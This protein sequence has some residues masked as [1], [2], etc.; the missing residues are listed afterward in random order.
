MVKKIYRNILMALALLAVENQTIESC[1][2]F[3][4]A[5]T[6]RISVFKAELPGMHAFRP[7][8]YTPEL[9]YA[10][11]APERNSDWQAN[12]REWNKCLG[13]NMVPNDIYTILYQAGPEM[14]MLAVS[15]SNLHQT[16]EGNTF[17]ETLLKPQHKDWLEYL[18]FAKQNEYNN[19][20]LDNPWNGGN[21]KPGHQHRQLMETALQRMENGKDMNLQ[22][23]YAYQ[24]IR[25]YRQA[26]MNNET[27]G[28]YKRYFANRKETVL[29]YWAMLHYAEA[30]A[31]LGKNTEANYLFSLVFNHSAE[32]RVRAFKLSNKTSLA[33]ALA[34]AK[35]NDEKAG[36]WAMLALANPGP[37][38]DQI[39]NVYENNP[40]HHTMPLLVMREINKLEDW[41]FTPVMTNHQ[42]SF[43]PVIDRWLEKDENNSI[44]SV[45]RRNDLKYL[46]RFSG[47]LALAHKKL[48]AGL[49]DYI[50]LARGHL[51]LMAG[52]NS[53]ALSFFG[54]I[55]HHAHPSVLV[56]KDIALVLYYCFE[57]KAGNS[58]IKE[59][60][61]N[62]LIRLEKTAQK[63]NDY[64][65]VLHSLCEVVSR[66]YKAE[67][68]IVSAMLLK[69]KAEAYKNKYESN[70]MDWY[71][72]SFD[73]NSDG[74]NDNYYWYLAY[75]DRYALP[76]D[77]DQLI[78]RTEK[79]TKSSFEQFLCSQP[80]P[81]KNALLDLKGTLALRQGDIKAASLAFSAIP[82]GYWENVYE[83]GHYLNADPFLP[84][85]SQGYSN[86][87]KFNKAKVVGELL[88]LVDQAIK[89]PSK[90]AGTYI[91]AGHFFYNASYWG[92][93]WMMLSYSKTNSPAKN[94]SGFY[95]YDVIF[96]DLNSHASGF[97]DNFYQNKLATYYYRKAA[98]SNPDKEQ[99]AIIAF[100]NYCC[101]RNNYLWENLQKGWDEEVKPYQP[102]FLADLYQ[103][104]SNTQVFNELRCPL[105][106]DFAMQM[107]V[108]E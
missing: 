65:K 107:G 67:G 48:G 19:L 108:W 87:Y 37:A 55:P 23:R 28:L 78:A 40:L 9:M 54:H 45:N 39:R 58:K 80:L 90:A 106:D 5:E 13:S 24:L 98:E 102:G 27:T 36:I 41:I 79:T 62:T 82:D 8:F 31:A 6:Y 14:F 92:N 1:G 53:E 84:P 20:F 44:Q 66:A 96:G 38:L 83:F 2:W 81:P 12:C 46:E 64:M 74:Y 33:K 29:K 16:F 34:L 68:D 42:P 73:S 103:N 101:H 95:Y 105:M 11:Y 52:N 61:G 63:N 49:Y 47:F 99:Q 89:S 88:D 10:S 32:K 21:T 97:T 70:R 76:R 26:G 17:I 85:N 30:M 72:N 91:K 59:E 94:W 51:G 71:Y 100:M 69:L 25:L 43:H 86:P 60:L 77:I 104:Y 22:E 4:Y 56:Q 3:E 75:L 18:I 57:N 93:S 35:S 7:F 50:W 15:D